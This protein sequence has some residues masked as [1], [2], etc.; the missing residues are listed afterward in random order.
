MVVEY[1]PVVDG[2][3][4]LAVDGYVGVHEPLCQIGHGSLRLGQRR[5]GGLAALDAVDGKGGSPAGLIGCDI[6][7]LSDGDALGSV[8]PPALDDVG[9]SPGGVD[10]DAE[11]REVSVPVEDVSV[12]GA[13]RI[14]GTFGDGTMVL[15]GHGLL[16]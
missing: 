16:S 8:R 7:M 12:A 11:A 1:P 2:A 15:S 6:S 5:N 14:D 4:R 3:R 9:L 13:E 10:A